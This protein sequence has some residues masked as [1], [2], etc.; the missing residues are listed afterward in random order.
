MGTSLLDMAPF[1]PS[2]KALAQSSLPD[3]ALELTQLSARLSGQL[4]RLTLATITQYMGV[5]NSYYSNLIEGNATRPH[6]IRAAQ[7]SDYNDDPAKRDLQQESLAHISVQQWLRDRNPELDVIFSPDF[8]REIHL[9]FYQQMPESLWAIKD[10][11]GQA[12]DTVVAG[13][14]R[15]R[16]VKVGQHIPPAPE[17]VGGLVASFC[18]QYKSR[19]FKGDRKLIAI[20]AAHH[21]FAWIHPFIDGN[22]RV[23]RLLTDAALR[24]VGLESYGAWCLSRGLA[25]TSTEY[26]NALAVADRPRQGNYDGCGAL[27]EDGLVKLCDYLF[28]TA[29]DQVSYM[30]GLLDLKNLRARINSYV[31]AR[32]DFRVPGMTEGLKSA[33]GLVLYTAF[34]HGD[35][36]RALALEL[37]AMPERSARRLLAQLKREGLLSETSSKSPLRWEIP[38]HTEA[39]Y[40]PE[41][42]PLS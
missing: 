9:R 22:G 16:P 23:G 39:W 25:R 1:T 14:W 11:G 21:R 13:E 40:F 38:E 42:A 29:I 15:D 17:S 33:A 27:T 35:I 18:E 32:N 19:R 5:I 6:E 20:L 24:A 37:C 34:I 3:K 4:P 10:D 2:D 7:R 41:L 28:S 12:V 26:K 31:Q 30:S 36:D 8:I